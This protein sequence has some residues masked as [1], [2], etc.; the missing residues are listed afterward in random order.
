MD[1]QEMVIHDR[2]VVYRTAGDGPVVLLIHGMAGS[3]TT[4]KHVMPALSKEFTVIA[5]DLLGHGRSD[6]EPDDYSLGSFASG[7]RDLLVALG[8]ERATIVGQSLGG[9]IAMQL[10]Y[11]H[12]ERC[13]RL[14]LVGSGGLGREVN[15]VLRL[16]TYPGADTLLRIASSAPVRSAVLGLG[17]LFGRAGMQPAPETD[18]LW[19][20]YESLAD[21][22]TRKAFLRTLRAV[23]DTKGQAVSAENRLHLAAE[24]P[25]LI[26][27]GDSDPI[28]PVDH[29]FAAHDGIA[30][31]RLEIFEGAGHYPHC[32]AP[33][34]F[35]E[36]LADFIE[37]TI[38]VQISISPEHV[39]R[40]SDG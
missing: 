31:S 24:M 19:R 13:E 26:V 20:S 30:G 36:V 8:H 33:D 3:A 39:L 35:V 2:R 25:T 21:A 10:A 15:P 7:L 28:I 14:A 22:S 40:S 16:L 9:G 34:R 37:S 12:P 29:A 11:Q 27:W 23:I 6:K 17:S 4:W 5:P 32:E 38:P 18:E 1:L